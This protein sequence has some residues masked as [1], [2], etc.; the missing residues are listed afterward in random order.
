MFD[1][2]PADVRSKLTT[3]PRHVS[4]NELLPAAVAET[5]VT[6]DRPMWT[7]SQM[8]AELESGHS[9]ETVREKLQTLDELDVCRSMEAN[10][11]RIYWWNDDRSRWPI[12]PDVDVEGGLTVAALLDP[13]YAKWAL[14]GVTGPTLAGLPLLL[15]VFQ[16]SGRLSTPVT[17]EA[18]LSA[19]LIVILLSYMVLIY[20]GILGLLGYVTGDAIDFDLF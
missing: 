4:G 1:S 20:S 19:G 10:N 5:M 9:R 18:L 6:H 8:R 12:P 7:A 17:G 2:L 11:G 13:W 16:A 15:G 14:V 3:D